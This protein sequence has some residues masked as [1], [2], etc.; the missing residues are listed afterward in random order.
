MLQ[1][2]KDNIKMRLYVNGEDGCLNVRFLTQLSC[3]YRCYLNSTKNKEIN[4]RNSP[5]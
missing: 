2:K 4:Y 3:Y 5:R 1:W